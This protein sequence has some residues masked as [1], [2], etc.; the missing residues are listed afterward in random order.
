MRSILI[1]FLCLVSLASAVEMPLDARRE[2]LR[3]LPVTLYPNFYVADSSFLAEINKV[4]RPGDAVVVSHLDAL[5]GS[6]RVSKVGLKNADVWVHIVEGVEIGQNERNFAGAKGIV[7]VPQRYRE[8][9]GYETGLLHGET[10]GLGIPLIVGLEPNDTRTLDNVAQ[11]AKHGDVITVYAW[12]ELTAGRAAF[13]TYLER[14]VRTAKEANPG[15][16]VEVAVAV[17]RTTAATL[18]MYAVLIDSADLADRVAIY[19]N[20]SPEAAQSL[21]QLMHALRT[22]PDSSGSS[23]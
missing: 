23:S 14:I 7:Y 5:K 9:V 2:K 4:T 22:G 3:G 16:K 17:T 12:R 19:C 8:R 1:L 11:I 20:D 15:I 6:F 18:A 21:A 13:R 10:Q